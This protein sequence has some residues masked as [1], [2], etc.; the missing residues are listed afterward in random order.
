MFRSPPVHRIS[1]AVSIFF[2]ASIAHA[3]E[4]RPDEARLRT[5]TIDPPTAT[6]PCIGNPVTPL[7]AVETFNTCYD[8]NDKQLCRA[9]GYTPN[10]PLGVD[11]YFALKTFHYRA[12]G[13]ATLKDEH[14]P[15]WARKSDNKLSPW[16]AGD[17]A[18][19][20]Y[21]ETCRPHDP[22]V[23]RTREAGLKLGE[24][25]PMTSCSSDIATYILRGV[26]DQWKFIDY[27]IA[28]RVQGQENWIRTPPPEPVIDLGGR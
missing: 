4:S 18:L 26:R 12:I 23:K 22:C 20:V 25:C 2:A 19:D 15:D 11:G 27:W 28:G 5:M 6:S 8:W 7:C 21:W 3:L 9:V 14:I 1:L 17:L 10:V 24:G 16:S 13:E